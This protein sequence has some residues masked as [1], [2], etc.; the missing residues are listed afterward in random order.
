MST[1]AEPIQFIVET[2]SSPSEHPGRPAPVFP[3]LD[4]GSAIVIAVLLTGAIGIAARNLFPSAFMSLLYFLPILLAAGYMKWWE[5]ICFTL[6]CT[7]LRQYF[8][9][10]PRGEDGILGPLMSFVA[11]SGVAFLAREIHQ[12]RQATRTHRGQLTWEIQWR[13]SVEELLR[14]VMEG[15]PAAV[16]IT[17]GQGK[18]AMANLTA[19][20]M[21][22]ASDV[23]LPG[24]ALDNYLPGLAQTRRTN[25]G[26]ERA[27]SFIECTGRRKGGELFQAAV[28]ISGFEQG[29]ELSLI[30]II[31]DGSIQPDNAEH[32]KMEMLARGARTIMGS[33]GHE[34]RNLCRALR[35]VSANLNRLPAVAEGES[36]EALRM[37]IESAERLTGSGHDRPAEEM[38]EVASV[39]VVLDRLRMIMEPAFQEGQIR[40]AW[41]VAERLPLVRADPHAL[42]RV[43][44]NLAWSAVRGLQ[45]AR[46][47]KI[48]ISAAAERRSV[49]IRLLHTAEP[50]GKPEQL[51]PRL[52]A[53]LTEA[54]MA[55]YV[56]RS[57]VR[58]FGGELR[59]EGIAEQRGYLVE[60][61]A[62]KDF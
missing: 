54:E 10:T 50:V 57:L 59:Y 13:K 34:M 52:P 41:Q 20:E 16:L 26:S 56:S 38:A 2:V 53:G 55:L 62:I 11:Y 61:D 44:L 15:I 23:L 14:G 60:L 19:Q 5:I 33:F 46:R 28:W 43:L 4:R 29:P 27:R 8:A 39:R 32:M 22:G 48:V 24:Q 12:H 31:F 1:T 25:P 49:T 21:F 40:V 35:L 47:K 3:W 17:D 18:I 36:G 45:D 42:L 7:I 58:S 37:L 6:A 30:T 9:P 51:F